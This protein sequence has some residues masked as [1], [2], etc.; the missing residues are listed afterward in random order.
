MG[1][2]VSRSN[3]LTATAFATC[4]AFLLACVWPYAARAQQPPPPPPNDEPLQQAKGHFEAGKNAYN[5]GDYPAAIR[6]FKAAEALRPS[7]ILDYNIGLSNEKLG[8][9]RVA[10]KYYKRYLEGQPQAANRAT[11]EGSI[12]QLEREIAAAPPPNSPPPPVEQPSDLPP[13]Q[14]NQPPPTY[15]SY[16]PYAS[17]PPPYQAAPVKK[18]SYWWVALIIVGGAAI[19][20]G[21]IVY[22]AIVYSVSTPSTFDHGLNSSREPPLPG[23]ASQRTPGVG[24]SVFSF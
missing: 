16:D 9:K 18:K 1:P 20:V 21:V 24:N 14:P 3:R 19:L 11:V 4:F 2:M 7:P 22:V 23:N 12:G 10:V 13:Q 5:A 15:S 8:K 6:E 17:T